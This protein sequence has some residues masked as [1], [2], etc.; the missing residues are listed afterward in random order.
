[1]SLHLPEPES[2]ATVDDLV[3]EARATYERLTPGE[4][5]L[6]VQAGATL[7]DTRSPDQQGAQGLIPG[8]VHHP[9]STL[10]WR[11]DPDCPTSNE[12]IGLA[13]EV[14][15]ICREGYS[16][17]LAAAQLRAIGFER[18]TDVIGGVEAWKAAGLS[19]SDA[20]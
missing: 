12:P 19:V 1:M 9:L 7:V 3:A 4:A 5:F 2:R 6:R 18:A 15:L 14:I 8:A 17:I 11:L 20:A 10:L 13:T 16:S